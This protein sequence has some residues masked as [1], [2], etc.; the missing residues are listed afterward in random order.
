MTR[1]IG[2]YAESGT[3]QVRRGRGRRFMPHYSAADIRLPAQVDE[4]HD[5][6]SGPAAQKVLYWG[7]S[8]M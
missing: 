8:R 6:L 1:L 7:V 5:T 2:K 4:A 3:I